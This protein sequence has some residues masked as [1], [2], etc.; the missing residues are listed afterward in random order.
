MR[1][2]L[3][4]AV[5]ALIPAIAGAQFNGCAMGFC[6]PAAGTPSS[7]YVGPGDVVPGALFWG[8]LRAYSGAIVDAGT[9]PIVNVIKTTTSET[10]DII[11]SGTGGLGNTASCSG[12]SN[13]QA[14]ATFCGADCDVVTLYDQSG[15]GRNVTQATA[16]RQ[17]ALMFNCIGSLPCITFTASGVVGNVQVL[18][19]T[20][21]A[22][23]QPWT[24]V[25]VAK[26][27]SG[28][29]T[30]YV[31][32]FG[33]LG[34][35]PHLGFGSNGATVN[36]YSG[37]TLTIAASTGV[38]HATAYIGNGVSSVII[39]DNV[40]STGNGSTAG[41]TTRGAPFGIGSNGTYESPHNGPIMEAGVWAGAMNST[42]YG[43]MC[44]NQDSYWGLPTSC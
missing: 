16:V 5:L 20:M 27:V 19:G 8:G 17:P 26:Q 24:A 33:N 23:A 2:L 13:G 10:C 18:L 9:Q 1:R 15:N 44:Q 30:C 6:S 14:A 3:I 38:A 43:G 29:S 21:V 7:G 41:L 4:A 31:I 11:V 35:T 22:Q 40:T 42:Q 34:F 25:S 12:G 32:A 37:A 39:S 36:G 28:C